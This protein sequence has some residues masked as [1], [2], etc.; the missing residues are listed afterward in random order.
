MENTT[1]QNTSSVN[2]RPIRRPR[3]GTV[4]QIAADEPSLTAG[5]IRRDLFNRNNNGLVKTGAVIRRGRRL[6]LDR[7]LYLNWVAGNG[8]ELS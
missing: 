5:A 6:L 3:F 8:R 1:S 4:E 7:E 2:E